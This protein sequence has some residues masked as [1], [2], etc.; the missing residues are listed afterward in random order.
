[1][2]KQ[3]L[4]FMKGLPGSGK[5]SWATSKIEEDSAKGIVTKR[6]SKDNLREMLDN[7]KF[8]HKR[9]TFVLRVR[10]TIIKQALA[11]G[12]NVIV[13]DTNF[14]PFHY[15]TMK[16]IAK[17]FNDVDVQV[18]YKDTHVREC[19]ER[20]KKR[21]KPVGKKVILNMYWKY[22]ARHEPR[23]DHHDPDKLDCIIVDVDGTLTI[24][25]GHR[26]M[27][28]YWEACNDPVNEPIKNLITY[29]TDGHMR[30]TGRKLVVNVMTAREN[31]IDDQGY[32]VF[33]LTTQWLM[34]HD[35]PFDDLFMRKQGDHRS[36][37]AVKWDM[38]TDFIKDQYNVLYVLDDRE[39]VVEMWR[40]E[41]L[42]V[43]NVGDGL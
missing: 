24:N 36:D 22:V 41:N 14:N 8:S 19:I 20:D 37:T 31:L 2:M 35:I 9:E 21:E 12:H 5:T 1:M 16:A 29:I 3:T 26:S 38:Y 23:V 17:E 27:Y 11:N 34:E 6:V 40:K 4:Y 39:K 18:V 30:R 13:D 25:T 43:L 28:D 32:T 10:D 7:S 33:D 42:N 15:E